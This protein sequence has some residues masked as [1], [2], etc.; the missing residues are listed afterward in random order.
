MKVPPF[1]GPT[2][3]RSEALQVHGMIV[4]I[5]PPKDPPKPGI[6]RAVAVAGKKEDNK[7]INIAATVNIL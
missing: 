1:G 2:I 7:R 6:E 3:R 4:N 5:L